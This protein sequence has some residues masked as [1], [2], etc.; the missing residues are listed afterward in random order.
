VGRPV[1]TLDYVLLKDRNLPLAPRQVMSVTVI[2]CITSSESRRTE[3][4]RPAPSSP[5]LFKT[6]RILGTPFPPF[7][8]TDRLHIYINRKLTSHTDFDPE[9]G[10]SM[11]L[12]HF[13]KNTFPND[14]KTGK[15][16][17]N[18]NEKLI[19]VKKVTD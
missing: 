16:R 4:V 3:N 5:F 13:G 1:T 7:G 9:D 10:L 18:I 14:A 19:P 17:T 15:N 6:E 8:L 12:R 11:F 2:Y